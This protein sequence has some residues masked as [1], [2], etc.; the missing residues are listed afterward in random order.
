MLNWA[1]FI[2]FRLSPGEIN[3]CVPAVTSRARLKTEF[4]AVIMQYGFFLRP[5]IFENR[6]LLKYLYRPI[7]ESVTEPCLLSLY[8]SNSIYKI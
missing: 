2:L 4:P 6:I 8:R 5:R 7:R 1:Y 3:K